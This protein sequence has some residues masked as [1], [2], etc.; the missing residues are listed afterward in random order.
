MALEN[1]RQRLE[2]AWPTRARVDIRQ[3]GSEFSARL[4]FPYAES[5]E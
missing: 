1:I 4:V 2:L 5:S 3:E